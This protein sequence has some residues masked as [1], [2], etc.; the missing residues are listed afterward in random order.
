MKVYLAGHPGDTT[1]RGRDRI[2]SSLVRAER[3]RLRW[4][5]SYADLQWLKRMFDAAQN[6][7]R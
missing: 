6:Q 5:V 4:L 2:I 3:E 7:K 1:E